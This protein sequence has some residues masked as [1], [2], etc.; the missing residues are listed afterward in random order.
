[1]FPGPGDSWKSPGIRSE[2]V[3]TETITITHTKSPEKPVAKQVPKVNGFRE[4]HNHRGNGYISITGM[5]GQSNGMAGD[6]LCI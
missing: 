3:A 1:M 2:A 4:E 5:S 6:I